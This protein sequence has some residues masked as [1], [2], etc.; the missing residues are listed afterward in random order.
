MKDNRDIYKMKLFE[1][2][3]VESFSD[4]SYFIR[5]PGGWV[6]TSYCNGKSSC[7]VPFDN[8]FYI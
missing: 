6:F 2:I 3:K 5:V 7:F 8:E 1:K 4:N